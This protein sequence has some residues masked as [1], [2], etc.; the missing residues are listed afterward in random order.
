MRRFEYAL[1]F[2][3]AFA[4][5]W[6]VVFGIRPRR[7]IVALTLSAGLFVQ[8]QFEGYRWQMIPLY[9]AAL[10]LAVGD[11]FFL[12]RRLDW[13]GRVARALLGAIGLAL[14]SGLPVVFPVPELPIPAG[15]E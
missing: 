11:I 3:A 2:A 10:G 9:L 5:F 7:G 12:E 14:V 1:L 4:V 8:L 6:P 15:P 13:S